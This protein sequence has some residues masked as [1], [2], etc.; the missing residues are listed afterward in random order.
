MAE[1]KIKI[2]THVVI[3]KITKYWKNSWEMRDIEKRG[4]KIMT[5][6][7]SNKHFMAEAIYNDR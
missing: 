2:S 1:F 7:S 6:S 3:S 4:K 5:F